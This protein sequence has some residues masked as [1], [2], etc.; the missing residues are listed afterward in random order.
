M[1]YALRTGLLSPRTA[2]GT[3][4]RTRRHIDGAPS[5]DEEENK[6]RVKNDG[7]AAV[8]TRVAPWRLTRVLVTV[9]T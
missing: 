6:A 8:G 3:L 2:K 7:A 5:Y 4:V 1:T 9:S